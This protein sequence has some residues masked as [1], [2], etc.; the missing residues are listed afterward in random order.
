MTGPSRGAGPGADLGPGSSSSSEPAV[1]SRFL[2]FLPMILHLSFSR[3]PPR[4][5][6]DS[7]RKPVLLRS[8]CPP[9][10]GSVMS[11]ISWTSLVPTL[12]I[13]S[14]SLAWWFTEPKTARINLI[15][16]AGAALFCWA[17]APEL[18]R[19]LSYSSYALTADAIAALRLRFVATRHAN[20]LLT[21]FAVG[22]YVG[23]AG[24]PLPSHRLSSLGIMRTSL[25]VWVGG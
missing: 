19:D 10:D 3:P 2:P 13:L 14:A 16:A 17:V 18:C 23:C 24:C 4:C 6:T 21:G 7:V 20:M 9:L 22:W 12:L 25:G 1:H 11:W 15:A 8:A 5:A